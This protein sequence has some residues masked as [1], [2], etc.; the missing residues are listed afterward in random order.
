MENM[1]NHPLVVA[2]SI[3][4]GC[5]VVF[6]VA[7]SWNKR[8]QYKYEDV[9]LQVKAL[10]QEEI[11]HF[12]KEG[13]ANIPVGTMRS[14]YP[15]SDE[16]ANIFIPEEDNLGYFSWGPFELDRF[17]LYL[18]DSQSIMPKGIVGAATLPEIFEI[19]GQSCLTEGLTFERKAGAQESSIHFEDYE[20]LVCSVKNQTINT[21]QG[22]WQIAKNEPIRMQ[23]NYQSSSLESMLSDEVAN[24]EY[25]IDSTLQ[26]KSDIS[27]HFPNSPELDDAIQIQSL[28]TDSALNLLEMKAE[29]SLPEGKGFKIGQCDYTDFIG[30]RLTNFTPKTLELH[31]ISYSSEGETLSDKCKMHVMPYQLVK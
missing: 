7:I 28:Y 6:G 25:S 24:F 17:S 26:D 22:K 20:L 21:P 27:L 4:L 11:E 12:T 9:S 23:H 13:I 29:I 5:T 10:T 16:I 8:Q 19:D 3:V 14:S 30:V 2:L 18:A 1:K 15:D 31:V